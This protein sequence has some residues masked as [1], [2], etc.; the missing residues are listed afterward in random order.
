MRRDENT[1][2]KV[3][4]LYKA[5]FR[6]SGV[7]AAIMAWVVIGICIYLN[8]W[9]IF[10]VHA[11]SDLGGPNAYMPW[12]YNLGLITTGLVI[13][14]YSIYLVMFSENRLESVASGFMF[15]AG[16]FLMLIGIYPSGT[17]PHNFVSTWFFLQADMAI[18]T[19]GLGLLLRGQKRYGALFTLMGILGPL[20]AMVIDWPSAA[21]VEA[22]GIVIIDLWVILMLK[23]PQKRE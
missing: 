10:T 18:L 19:W 8:P 12:V 5:L 4:S 13:L 22:Y 21:T 9:F 20:I 15:I 3:I 17:K 16:L 2:E 7:I 6:Y 14:A 23:I 1:V 11:F